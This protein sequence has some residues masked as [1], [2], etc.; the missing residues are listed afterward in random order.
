MQK[1]TKPE[2]V[3][4]GPAVFPDDTWLKKYP[5]LC[6]YLLDDRWDD[7]TSR[8]PS[9]LSLSVRD[10][11]IALALNDKALKQSLYTQAGT[12]VAALA[13][14]EGALKDGT[15]MWRPWN[16]GKRK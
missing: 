7:G 12:V 5:V 1:P 8:E 4:S 9:A 15:G 3:R 2:A 14:M 16:A 10:G 11:M 6:N 13:L